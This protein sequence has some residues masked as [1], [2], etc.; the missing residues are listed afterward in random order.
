[1]PNISIPTIDS[2]HEVADFIRQKTN[3]FQPE[4]AMILGSGIGILAEE[5]EQPTVIPY[6]K[7]PHFPVSTVAGHAGQLVFGTL[8]DKK[9]MAMQGRFHFYEGYPIQL[10][11]LPVR[12]MKL[13]GIQKMLVTNAAGGV[14]PNFQVGDLMLITDHLNLIF[15]NPLMG[16]NM[17]EFGPR[18][19]D[20]SQT[21]C[22]DLQ[23]LA[24]RVAANQGI[25][26]QQGVYQMM[27]G[28]TYETPAEVRMA[29]FL[30]ADAVGMSTVPEAMAAVHCGIKVLGISL[31]SN[32]AAG[33]SETA[34]SHGE[35]MDTMALVKDK[36]VT[37][38]RGIVGEL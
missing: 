3:Q 35:V 10:L 38:V 15:K 6:H 21:Y 8:A 24:L 11:A 28:P 30:G 4:I 19:P 17:D 16:D 31:I 29:S 5:I 14:N 37:L 34:L 20:T 27:T 13:L 22:A 1:M 32:M 7:I 25:A 26:I 33:I 36:F 12:V 18:F 2:I 23:Q 9:V